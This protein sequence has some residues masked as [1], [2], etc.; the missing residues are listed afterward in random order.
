MGSNP[1]FPTMKTFYEFMCARIGPLPAG[2]WILLL[3]FG[4]GSVF[5]KL[6]YDKRE[7]LYQQRVENVLGLVEVNRNRADSLAIEAEELGFLADSLAV[8]AARRDTV[9]RERIVR[10]RDSLPPAPDTCLAYI[11]PRD[12]IIDSL[13]AT[14]TMRETAFVAQVEASARL[15]AAYASATANIDSLVNLIHDRPRPRLWLPALTG[16]V[17]AGYCFD[18]RPCAGVGLGLQ[19]RLPIG[20][21]F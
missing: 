6:A 15:R 18:G 13:L 9:I 14:S 16:G 8:V 12:S 17:F 1:I 19:W 3:C 5:A 20:G 11:A 21:L 7:V 4:V 2:M 10:V